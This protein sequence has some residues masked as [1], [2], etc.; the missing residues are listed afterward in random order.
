MSDSSSSSDRKRPIE[1]KKAR[2]FDL[3]QIMAQTLAQ[4]PQYKHDEESTHIIPDAST[5]SEQAR[6]GIEKIS[7]PEKPTQTAATEEDSDDDVGPALPPGFEVDKTVVVDDPAAERQRVEDEESDG[8][9]DEPLT[10]ATLIPAE[11]EVTIRT[12]SDKAVTALAID[13]QG[14]KFA[15]GT[16]GYAV[17][18]HDYQK[19]DKLFKPYRELLPAECHVINSLSY[20]MNGERLL[21]TTGEAIL[22]IL[23]RNGQQ[24]AETVRGDQYL[25]DVN[26]TKGHTAAVNAGCWHP[27]N[28]N[29][30][31]T[32]S[33]DGTIRLWNTE[34]FKEVTKVINTQKKVIRCRNAGGKRII[35]NCC[36]YSRDGKLIAAGCDDGSIH[37]WKHGG[38]Y[39]STQYQNR[40]AHTATVTCIQFSLDNKKLISRSMDGTLKIWELAKFKEPIKSVEGLDAVFN[41]TD[42]GYSPD[43][44]FIFTGTQT[45]Q[46]G[47]YSGSLL[48][49]STEDLDLKYKIEYPN[50]G[51][52][53]ILWHPKI[54][55]ILVGLSDGNVKNYYDTKFSQ[56]GARLCVDKQVRRPRATE[57][58]KEEMILAPLSLEMFQA[59][60]ED[61]EEK[62][63]T[64]FRLKKYLRMYNNS[65][66]PSFRTPADIP[67][68]GPGQGGRVAAAGSTLHSYIAQQLGVNRNK[69]FIGDDDIRQSILRHAEEAEK[70]PLY[71][72]KAYAKTQPKPVFQ[73]DNSDDDDDKDGQP[74]FKAQKLG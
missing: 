60:G 62:E 19:M 42:C 38:L 44:N 35:P 36:A 49:F 16:Q 27:Y 40:K 53:K 58:V 8:E 22:K 46:K 26:K 24:W 17:N 73:A 29:E 45:L 64:E 70:N 11:S 39:V 74:V 67:K 47:G 51:C 66:R 10:V 31:M 63:V 3:E 1:T 2:T 20:N 56:R 18:L 4:A 34:D 21:I 14:C 50:A 52:I 71:I 72:N 23:D 59:K 37:M 30:F 41:R 68:D 28:K 65:Q 12:G 54:E 15:V 6:E 61:A 48:F 32:C 13:V 57:V 43:T 55:Q 33:D 69:E 25:V 9:Y 7:I 5:S